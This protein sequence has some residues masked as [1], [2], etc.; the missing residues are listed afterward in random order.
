L[1][2]VAMTR[3]QSW[4][5]VAAAGEVKK[6]DCWYQLIAAGMTHARAAVTDDGGMVLTGHAA[7]PPDATALV[8][9]PDV[10]VVDPW[11]RRA[12][13]QATQVPAPL[14]P[15]GLPG[16]KAL[17][18]ED[19]QD[20]QQA[21]A[22]GTQL[23]ALLEILPLHVVADWPAM[24]HAMGATGALLDEAARII[25]STVMAHLF[26]PGS[27]AEVAVTARLQGRVMLGSIDRLIVGADVVLAVDFKSNR[28]VPETPVQVP[29]GILGQMGAYAAALR[30]IYP[31]KRVETAVLWTR[32]AM[33]M[34]LPDD[35][36]SDAFA[37]L[38]AEQIAPARLRPTIP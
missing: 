20:T 33:L 27:L 32:T 11:A 25:Q 8:A 13:P 29:S 15:S 6:D 21:L 3:A 1:L 38:M 26:G 36:V 35:L 24:A 28:V 30:Q 2:Y 34:T 14:S 18:G 12:A 5:V 9:V 19:G 37:S 10:M 4:L 31:G 23:H 16:A 7:W 17:P 22:Q